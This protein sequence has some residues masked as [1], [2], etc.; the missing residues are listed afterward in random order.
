[1]KKCH[2]YWKIFVVFCM[3]YLKVASSCW[4][5]VPAAKYIGYCCFGLQARLAV[6]LISFIF[7]FVFFTKNNMKHQ[8]EKTKTNFAALDNIHTWFHLGTF[9]YAKPLSWPLFQLWRF[10][11]VK[12]SIRLQIF[13]WIGKAMKKSQF[14]LNTTQSWKSLNS[15]YF[16]NL[17]ISDDVKTDLS[18]YGL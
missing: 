4:A 10:C 15:Q 12:K 1:M 5:A 9:G 17:H 13:S 16:D 11:Q 7:I 14:I 6:L 2:I 8:C 18:T 3:A